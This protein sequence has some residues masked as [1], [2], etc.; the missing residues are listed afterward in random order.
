MVPHGYANA[1]SVH[2]NEALSAPPGG[3]GT[4]VN[5]LAIGGD[6]S[7]YPSKGSGAVLIA[8]PGDGNV[9]G[10][11]NVFVIQTHTGGPAPS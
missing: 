4:A 10:Q 2:R 8:R 11:S 6:Y 7:L 5:P 3:G 1:G 9:D